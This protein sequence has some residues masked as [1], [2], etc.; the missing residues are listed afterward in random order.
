MRKR[1]MPAAGGPCTL[2][3]FFL[4]SFLCSCDGDTWTP[5]TCMVFDAWAVRGVGE[6]ESEERCRQV[7]YL[8]LVR[9]VQTLPSEAPSFRVA[10]QEGR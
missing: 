3:T 4:I 5:D 8:G 9:H 2:S 6:E 7:G 1:M 10:S